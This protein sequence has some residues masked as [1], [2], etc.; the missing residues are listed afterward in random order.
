M[1]GVRRSG[2]HAHALSLL[3]SLWTTDDNRHA[4][5]FWACWVEATFV[6]FSSFFHRGSSSA[7]Y[8]PR[9]I[10]GFLCFAVVMLTTAKH[11]SALTMYA[12]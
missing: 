3:G 12:F 9:Q 5:G 2:C 4:S 6:F 10:S 11:L 1:L 7:K 8:I